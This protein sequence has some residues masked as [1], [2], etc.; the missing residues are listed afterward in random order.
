M[1]DDKIKLDDYFKSEIERVSNLEINQIQGEID[2]IKNKSIEGLEVEAQR[3]AKQ[4]RVQELKEMQSE[5]D[6][7]LSRVH[8]ETNRKLMN[9]RKELS[10]EV[11]AEVKAKLEEFTQGKDYEA[12]LVKKAKE[13]S[14]LS[15]GHVV[16]YVASKDE[17]FLKTICDAYANDCEGRVDERICIGGFRM[18][19]SEEGVDVDE[20]FDTGIE[21]Q[22][23][24]FYTNS[25][26]FIK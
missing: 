14:Q 24:W 15:F 10:N 1:L 20:T 12:Y 22:R 7:A 18:E 25:G 6:I 21:E 17:K 19:C 26:L 8:E 4:L 13:L 11:F 5:H 16:I 9:K 23:G 2:D 3:Y